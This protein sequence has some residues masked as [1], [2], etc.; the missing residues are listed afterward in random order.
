MRGERI[1]LSR[2]FERVC[3]M[4]MGEESAQNGGAK[5][6]AIGTYARHAGIPMQKCTGNPS[7]QM[8]IP[9]AP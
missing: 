4:S 1:G 7:N 9:R 6:I 3:Q 5:N 8:L 2:A